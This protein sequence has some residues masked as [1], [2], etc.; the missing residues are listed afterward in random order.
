MASVMNVASLSVVSGEP[1][2]RDLILA[3]MLGMANPYKV[4]ELI[5]ANRTELEEYGEISPRRGEIK[6]YSETNPKGGG[7]PSTE[8][9]LNEPQALL[10]CMFSRTAKAAE[11]RR[12]L[13]SVFMEY[14]LRKID[15]PRP[16]TPVLGL[17]SS[18]VHGDRYLVTYASGKPEAWRLPPGVTL[19]DT[20]DERQMRAVIDTLNMERCEM[21]ID[22]LT[23]RLTNL[24]LAFEPTKYWLSPDRIKS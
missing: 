11:V 14:R 8:F 18:A 23:N 20:N 13:I 10:I 17:P 9:Y 2:V 21:V 3:E 4:R 7:R 5:G 15:P 19:F 24:H 22:A 16:I 6:K 12:S 1:R